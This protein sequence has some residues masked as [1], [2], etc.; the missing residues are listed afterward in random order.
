MSDPQG[1]SEEVR[2]LSRKDIAALGAKALRDAGE[3]APAVRGLATAVQ[4]A[5]SCPPPNFPPG[6]PVT[7][8]RWKVRTTIPGPTTSASSRAS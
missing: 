2:P 4:A 1:I 6:M 7:S 3:Q 5:Q 8:R